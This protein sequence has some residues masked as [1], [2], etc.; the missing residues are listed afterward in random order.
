MAEPGLI[1]FDIGG[2]KCAVTVG[3]ATGAIVET[4]RLPTTG[5][6]AAMLDRLADGAR[7]LLAGHRSL[8]AAAAGVSCGGPLDSRRGLILSPPNLPGWD[9]V[10]VV[11]R[12]AAALGVPCFL[13][14]DANACALAEAR[15]GAGRGAS[16][17]V[18]CTMGTGFGAGLVLDGRLCRGASGGAGEIGHVRLTEGGPIGY[19][20]AG[21]V[22][23]Y[24]GGSGI[25]ALARLRAGE[26][27]A[28]GE[29]VA[30][31]GDPASLPA[32]DAKRVAEAAQAG[33]SHAIA[34]YTEVGRMLGRALAI[35]VDLLNPEVIVVGSIFARAER[36][37]RPAMEAELAAEALPA[38]LAACRIVPAALGE[39]LGEHAAL[40]VA[41]EGLRASQEGWPQ[42]AGP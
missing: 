8:A 11:E 37:L 19:G 28:R 15:L 3:T 7:R 42:T 30:F 16:S 34:I 22:E 5:S 13:E 9:E 14:N 24:V 36:L 6:A 20:K 10:P 29:A 2:T 1:G 17:V 33:D 38:N 41:S 12:L 25:A 26:A 21:S 32:L 31:C 39:S 40:M 35:V 18:F 4:L 27:L 23:G